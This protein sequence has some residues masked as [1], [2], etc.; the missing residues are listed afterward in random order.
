MRGSFVGFIDKTSWVKN[1]QYQ[2][3]IDEKSKVDVEKF[4]GNALRFQ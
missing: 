3:N 2:I 4:M 1:K